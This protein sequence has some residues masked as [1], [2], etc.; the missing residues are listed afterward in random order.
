M[1]H[2]NSTLFQYFGEKKEAD[3]SSHN[4]FS[5]AWVKLPSLLWGFFWSNRSYCNQILPARKA[6]FHPARRLLPSRQPLKRAFVLGLNTWRVLSAAASPGRRT[7]QLWQD[8]AA[9][10]SGAAAAPRCCWHPKNVL[11]GP[12]H[13]QLWVVP[14]FYGGQGFSFVS[15]PILKWTAS[16]QRVSG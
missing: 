2:H 3:K 7:E 10:A 16:L 11:S 14:L 5:H 1:K 9:L 8:P 4:G 13:V 12:L 15:F 6:I